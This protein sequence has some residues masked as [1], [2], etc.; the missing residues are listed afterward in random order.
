MFAPTHDSLI[1]KIARAI[2]PGSGWCGRCG[3]PWRFVTEHI[4]HYSESEGVFALCEPCWLALEPADRLPYYWET[5]NISWL[6]PDL[7]PRVK[8]TILTDPPVSP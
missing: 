7:W 5:I 8:R 1:A 2:S 3:T 4:V 6:R